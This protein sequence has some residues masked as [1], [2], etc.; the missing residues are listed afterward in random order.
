MTSHILWNQLTIIK[1]ILSVSLSLYL[2]SLQQIIQ[3]HGCKHLLAAHLHASLSYLISYLIIVWY[4][5]NLAGYLLLRVAQVLND[6]FCFSYIYWVTINMQKQYRLT[7][8]YRELM[9]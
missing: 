2:I 4:V 9:S 1:L 5:K 3:S 8:V 7:K 6:V